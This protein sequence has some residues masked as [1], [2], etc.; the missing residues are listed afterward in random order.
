MFKKIEENMEKLY[1][2]IETFTE[3]LE[4]VSKKTEI[5]ITEK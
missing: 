5:L 4:C 2:N 1:V 3:Q